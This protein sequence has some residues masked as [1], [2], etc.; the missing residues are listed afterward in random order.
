MICMWETVA[1]EQKKG[2]MSE[3]GCVMAVRVKIVMKERGTK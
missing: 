1:G 2:W 3:R